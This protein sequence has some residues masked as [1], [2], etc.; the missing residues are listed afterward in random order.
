MLPPPLARM[1]VFAEQVYG[2]WVWPHLSRLLSPI[3]GALPFSAGEVMAAAYAL[4]LEAAAMLTFHTVLMRRRRWTNALA[5]GARRAIR[6]VGMVVFLFYVLWGFNYA[7]PAFEKRAGWPEWTGIEVNELS[8]LTEAAVEAANQAYLDVH[9][10][11]DAG[12][13]TALPQDMRARETAIDE[14]WARTADRL[15]LRAP[16]ASRYGR[17]K[18]PFAS[19]LLPMV[20]IYF[21]FTAEAYVAGGLPAM[22]LAMT[23]A[24]EKAHQRGIAREAEATFLGFIAGA[25]APHPSAGIPR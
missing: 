18:R 3:T 12:E 10:T 5:G 2:S 13:P 1:P 11:P 15:S 22:S 25:L 9:G 16:V 21:P 17:V 20:G 19:T 23:I 14:G 6:D 7:V 24:H 4:W 8:A